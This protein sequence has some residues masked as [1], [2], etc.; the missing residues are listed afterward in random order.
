MAKKAR[1]PS[2]RGE[3]TKAGFIPAEIS[4]PDIPDYVVVELRYEAPVAFSAARFSAP[5]DLLV[6]RGGGSRRWRDLRGRARGQRHLPVW[7]G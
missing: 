1:S 3:K 2:Q 4:T 6:Q 5:A 7:A